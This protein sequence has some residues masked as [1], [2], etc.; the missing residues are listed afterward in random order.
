VKLPSQATVL[1]VSDTHMAADF[2]A[3]TDMWTSVVRFTER[4]RPDLVIHTGDVVN[5]DPDSDQDYEF[6][7]FQM[8]R[9]T[10]PWRIVPGNHDVGD[11]GPDP[12][13]GLITGER[14]ARFRRHFGPDRWS[15][16]VGDWQL[17]GLN[18]LLFD[19]HLVEEEAEQWDW[20]EERIGEA[21]GRPV[22]L[23]MHKPPSV[24][25]LR[26]DLHVNKA[27]GLKARA[28]LLE[29]AE[30]GLVK[31][32]GSGHL[33]EHVVL[34][35]AGVLLVSAPSVGPV[36]AGEVTWQLGLRCNGAVEYRFCGDAVRV[37]LLRETDL[38]IKVGA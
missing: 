13:R 32:I 34:F 30:S 31:L 7:A 19:N 1:H 35:S 18:S 26:E 25:S 6:A 20:L 38:G 14:L 22:G 24:N 9:L 23:F 3:G 33:H 36:P 28:R 8:R 29:L 21:G 12:Y 4:T 15:V 5:D 17:I 27:I 37:R 16:T 11:S 10:T 2:P